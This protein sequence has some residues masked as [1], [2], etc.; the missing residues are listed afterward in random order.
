MDSVKNIRLHF[1]NV[2]IY[3]QEKKCKFGSLANGSCGLSTLVPSKFETIP[4][5][6]RIRLFGPREFE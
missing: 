6:L 2:V 1:E 3:F 4:A 5:E